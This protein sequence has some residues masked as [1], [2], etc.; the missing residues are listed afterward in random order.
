MSKE[1]STPHPA[2][3]SLEQWEAL[4]EVAGNLKKLA[5]WRALTDTDLFTAPSWGRGE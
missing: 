1:R 3:P 4:Y 2:E 5:P